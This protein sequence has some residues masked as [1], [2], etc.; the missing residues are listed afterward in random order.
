MAVTCKQCSKCKRTKPLEEF[1]TAPNGKYGRYSACKP[2]KAAQSKAWCAANKDRHRQASK[3][4]LVRH[5]GT[6]VGRHAKLWSAAKARATTKGLRFT[7]LKTDIARMWEDQAGLCA[8]LGLPFNLAQGKGQFGQWDS[9][10]IDRIDSSKGYT[11]DNVRLV[12]ISVNLALNQFGTDTFDKM[13][14]ARVA[15]RRA[16][17]RPKLVK[18]FT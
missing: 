10:S 4:R 14:E 9:P 2:C 6:L 5:Y 17:L 3:L 11:L 8:L 12:F 7:L 15:T 1:H 13:C 18:D 16:Q